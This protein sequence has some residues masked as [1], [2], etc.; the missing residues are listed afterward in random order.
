MDHAS[1]SGRG[2][3]IRGHSSGIRGHYP[4]AEMHKGTVPKWGPVTDWLSK[5][6]GM[7]SWTATATIKKSNLNISSAQKF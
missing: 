2:L 1:T 3:G 4:Q 7:C 6:H 5:V